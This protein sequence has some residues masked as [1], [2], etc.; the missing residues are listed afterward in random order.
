MEYFTFEFHSLSAVN[1]CKKCTDTSKN[2]TVKLFGRTRSYESVCVN[3]FG[4]MPYFYISGLE[5]MQF[6]HDE[7]FI[8]LNISSESYRTTLVE[9]VPFYNFYEGVKKFLKIECCSETVRRQLI[10]YIKDSPHFQLN[11]YEVSF[12][13]SLNFD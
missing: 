1:E 9:K 2:P 4:Y 12:I 5:S 3:V 8:Q 6:E 11:L 7:K 10:N 13:L